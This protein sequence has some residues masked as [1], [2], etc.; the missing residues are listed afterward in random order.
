MQY[1]T[2]YPYTANY[3]YSEPAWE[4]KMLDKAIEIFIE[5]QP[6]PE[7]IDAESYGITMDCSPPLRSKEIKS[8][9]PAEEENMNNLLV[10]ADVMDE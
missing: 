4:K 5:N 9:S 10:I 2:K 6:F 8:M 7:E 3:P 1:D